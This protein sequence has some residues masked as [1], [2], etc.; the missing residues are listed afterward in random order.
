MVGAR[1]LAEDEDRVGQL[2]V[3]QRHRALADAD[4]RR[5][6]R[7]GWLMAHVRAVGEV[8]G[9]ELA[10]EQLVKERGLLA[11]ARSEEHTSEL[12][13]LIRRSYAV[14]CWTTNKRQA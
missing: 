10:H 3:V 11:G 7:A 9:D 13:S 5:H 2:E 1:V 8:V 6:P 14:F 4:L 12:P